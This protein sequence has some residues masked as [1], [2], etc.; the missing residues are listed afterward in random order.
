MS[1]NCRLMS[2]ATPPPD[3]LCAIDCSCPPISL[4]VD[5][6]RAAW[7]EASERNDSRDSEAICRAW[8][9]ASCATLRASSP[10]AAPTS[11]AFP[12]TV[13]VASLTEPVGLPC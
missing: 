6:T 7:F 2:T 4:N 12:T 8:S 13:D 11:L 3:W 1:A 9:L 10:T 5:A